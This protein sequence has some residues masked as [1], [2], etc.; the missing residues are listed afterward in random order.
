MYSR[1]L[2]SLIKFRQNPELLLWYESLCGPKIQNLEL[3]TA[4]DKRY[5][6]VSITNTHG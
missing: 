3:Y 1:H 4:V 6:S 5:D 2:I